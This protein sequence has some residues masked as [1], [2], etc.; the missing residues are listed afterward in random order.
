[1]LD[2]LD[3]LH[4]L[5]LTSPVRVPV[6]DPTHSMEP[7]GSGNHREDITGSRSDPSKSALE[8]EDTRRRLKALLT[9]LDIDQENDIATTDTS[10][11]LNLIHTL[12]VTSQ[13]R[14]V[15][16][17]TSPRLQ[18]WLTSMSSCALVINGQMFSSEHET[19]RSP[20]SYFC[21]KFVDSIL[22]VS[23]PTQQGPSN[24][25][26][27][28]RWFCGQHTDVRTDFDAHTPGMLNN[29]LSQLIRQLV[30]KP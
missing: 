8:L 15:A 19:R 25:I 12:S 1:M 3:R 29:L 9:R 30:E 20:L 18:S 28:V 4:T 11:Q 6:V 22:T 27:V 24:P 2:S 26:F 7:I 5:L 17:I 14:A 21:A 10:I 23:P 16:L 13:D